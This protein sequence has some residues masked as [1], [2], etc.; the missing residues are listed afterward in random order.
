[1][2]IQQ[3]DENTKFEATYL[4]K[5]ALLDAYIQLDRLF[6]RDLK[7]VAELNNIYW[8]LEKATGYAFIRGLEKKVNDPKG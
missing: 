8:C 4:N 7:Y 5:E 3:F 6:H 2:T 1:M